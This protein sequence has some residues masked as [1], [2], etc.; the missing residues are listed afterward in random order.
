MQLRMKAKS[1]VSSINLSVNKSRQSSVNK[2]RQSLRRSKSI[3]TGMKPKFDEDLARKVDE[4]MDNVTD[5]KH[6]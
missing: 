5:P 3:M 4:H 2:S 6:I 1:R